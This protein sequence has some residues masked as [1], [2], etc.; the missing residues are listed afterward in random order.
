MLTGLSLRRRVKEVNREN[1][2]EIEMLVTAFS[3]SRRWIVSGG[4]DGDHDDSRR[5]RQQHSI[6]QRIQQIKI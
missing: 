6:L 2:V 4:S 1:L 3:I 5:Q